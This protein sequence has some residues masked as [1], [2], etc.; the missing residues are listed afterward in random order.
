MSP[1]QQI[2][3][4]LGAVEGKPYIDNAFNT[5]VW[6][7]DGSPHQVVNNIKLSGD[8]GMVWLKCRSDNH[9][10]V[11]ADTVRGSNKVLF[12]EAN[13]AEDTSTAYYSSLNNNGFTTGTWT[14]VSGNNKKF[15]AWSFKKSTGFFDVVTYTGNATAGRTVAHS[16]GSIPGCIMVKCT[17]L[18]R[19][20]AVYHRGMGNGKSMHL[21]GNGAQHDSVTYWND[22]DPT[23]SVF[24]LGT[25]NDTNKSGETYVAYVFAGGESTAS[26]ARSVEFDGNNSLSLGSTSDFSFPYDFTVEF[27]A[28]T[29]SY[30]NSP[31][32][33][34]FR[35]SGT[36]TGTT[37]RIVFYT[38]GNTG[39]PTFWLNG[40]ARITAIKP[41]ALGT[42]S[43]YALVRSGSTTT[44]YINGTAQGTYNDSTSY[45]NAP[46]MIGQRQGSS[47]T[48]GFDGKISNFRIFRGVAVYSSSF[49]PSTTPLTGN[50]LTKLLCCNDSSV[51]GKTYGGTITAN[52]SPTASTDSPFDDP[53][54]F[55]FGENE[56]QNVIKCGSYVG[57]GS[58]TG[59]I[60][61][62]GWEPQWLLI[63]RSS[64]SEDWMIF[65]CMRGIVT[66]GNDPNL[67]ANSS[68]AETSTS[69]EW[70]EATPTGFQLKVGY[71]HTNANGSTY[72]YVA[73]RR[74]D[75]YCGKPPELG[76]GVFAM[77]AGAGSSTIPNFTS[78]FPVDFATYR[79]PASTHHW[80]AGY[81]LL[82]GKFNYLNQSNAEG[83]WAPM[84]FDSNIG[85]Q[86]HS[87][88]GSSYQAWMWKRHAG[89]DVVTYNGN[90][91]AGHTIPHSLSKTPEMMWVKNRET[92]DAWKVYHKGLNGGTNP[93]QYY[94]GIDDD[95]S[96]QTGTSSW[97][98]TVPTST[99]FTVGT[100][101]TVNS[102]GNDYIALLFS[103]TDVS[104][105]GYYTGNGT[106]GHAITTGFQP[107]FV[108]I[109][110]SGLM[111]PW[112]VLDTTRGWGS[113]NDQVLKLDSNA[114]QS[115]LDYGAPASTGFT[116]GTANEINAN[117]YNYM[118]YAHS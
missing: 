32:F 29:D 77:A 115:S 107:R 5:D 60:I 101:S 94:I 63:K 116:L 85:F 98:N 42:W 117:N 28:L 11:L 62:L 41:T 34:D 2:F 30:S 3:L 55:A 76:T 87:T 45:G 23:A 51:T 54:G 33:C 14:G 96:Q 38:P 58:S 95:Y 74:S 16:L 67:R 59:P 113:G 79:E 31:Y 99:H 75:G 53:A 70:L 105:V 12:S 92:T 50:A 86:N 52:G 71:D 109:R 48:Q 83:N 110:A 88:H 46:L 9:S 17:S 7:G 4:G 36:D 103:T 80:E 40:S 26:T 6:V 84:V 81:R 82:Q 68:V 90:G 19:N 64:G 93:A 104:K 18:N 57:N 1:M 22:T 15:A 100:S 72:I 78:N 47:V 61:N 39:K 118:Y 49:K 114:A 37:N 89:F 27:W 106:S 97:N 69:Y 43:H 108:L 112:I 25:A 91:T 24:T 21:D 65:D 44:M 8:G 20:W 10:H 73:I 56:N 111:T 66:G 13:A 102:N 35:D